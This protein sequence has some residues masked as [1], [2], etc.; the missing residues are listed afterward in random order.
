MPVSV[1][2]QLLATMPGRSTLVPTR[3]G[4]QR[5]ANGRGR[6]EMTKPP[7][8]TDV[9]IVGAGPTGLTLAAFLSAGGAGVVLLDRAAEGAGTSRAAVVHARTLEV[10]DELDVTHNQEKR[11]VIT[12][13]FTVR[14][15]DR[16]LLTVPFGGL[17]TRRPYTLMVPQNV[18][19]QVLLDRLRALGGQVH[20][21]H[22]VTGVAQDAP[23]VT[24]TAATGETVRARYEVGADGMHSVVRERSGIGFAGDTYEQSFV[25]ADVLLVWLLLG[26]V[27]L[28]FFSV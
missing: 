19:E 9:V 22:E 14:D 4:H 10:L 16:V 27:V 2:Q 11:G 7:A 17:P 24:V 12:P 13:T 26:V 23:G 15:R 3:V 8:T 6:A 18:T 28:L 1:G 5:L 20:R 25:L 21:P